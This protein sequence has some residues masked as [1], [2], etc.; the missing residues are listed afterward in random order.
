MC[1]HLY[2]KQTLHGY[3]HYPPVNI[4]I[5]DL[6]IFDTCMGVSLYTVVIYVKYDT[7][8]A[9]TKL[10]IATTSQIRLYHYEEPT[11]LHKDDPFAYVMYFNMLFVS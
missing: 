1:L 5:L 8:G 3:L 4:F 7:L 2:T 11:I 9:G 6:E 10:S